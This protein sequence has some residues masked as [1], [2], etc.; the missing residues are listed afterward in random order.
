MLAR[1]INSLPRGGS[2]AQRSALADAASDSAVGAVSLLGGQALATLIAGLSSIA[3]ARVLGPSGYGRYSLSTTV[4]GFLML[5]TDFGVSAAL[6]REASRLL[7]ERE[8]LAPLAGVALRFVLLSSLCA[9][10]V[11]LPL[12]GALASTLLRRPDM[13][14]L[15][16]LTLPLVVCNA[17][18]NLSFSAL[19]G[20]G[21]SKAVAALPVVRDSVRAFSRRCLR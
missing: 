15:V 1:F 6:A 14:G 13:A 21:D 19:L 7:A 20:L 9:A 11:G 3:L 18:F 8:A 17:L 5:A 2:V 12:S 10:A 4:A 16:E